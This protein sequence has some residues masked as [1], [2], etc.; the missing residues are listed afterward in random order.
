[1]LSTVSSEET[2]CRPTGEA[3]VDHERLRHVTRLVGAQGGLHAILFGTF[4]FLMNLTGILHWTRGWAGGLAYLVAAI[5]LVAACKRWIP[6]YYERRFGHVKAQE[7][8]ARQFVIFLAVLVALAF[9]GQPVASYFEPTV[10]SFLGRVH[11]MISD[12]AQQ[13]NLYPPF[14]WMAVFFGS[15]RWPLRKMERQRLCFE[16][17]GL[18]AFASIALFPTWHPDAG[19][20]VLWR[21]LNAGGLGLSFIATGLY[22]HLVLVR[23]L[24][25]RV[26]EGD[27]E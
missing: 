16:F 15:L 19:K 21:V 1:M 12:P 18:V 11:A 24:P 7:M 23:A 22:D 26:A 9:F 5:L 14:L 4:F 6:R 13:V 17:A 3:P 27:D 20:L 10:S 2:N 25:K 8:S